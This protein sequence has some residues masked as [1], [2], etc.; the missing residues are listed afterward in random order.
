M[1]RK[2]ERERELIEDIYNLI[3]IAIKLSRIICF[4]QDGNRRPTPS[5]KPPPLDSSF[6]RDKN[7]STTENSQYNLR[8]ESEISQE[9]S[10]IKKDASHQETLIEDNDTKDHTN[11]FGVDKDQLM[12]TNNDSVV[13]NTTK[14][15]ETEEST[16]K[17]HILNH[18]YHTP[19]KE[20]KINGEETLI[21]GVATD[22][23][24]PTTQHPEPS[25]IITSLNNQ[26]KVTKPSKNDEKATSKIEKPIEKTTKTFST[27]TLNIETSSSVQV[28]ESIPT[29]VT[30]RP[31]SDVS[32][33]SHTDIKSSVNLEPSSVSDIEYTEPMSSVST[34][35]DGLPTSYSKSS[36]TMEKSVRPTTSIVTKNTGM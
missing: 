7:L 35:T 29:K 21:L 30:L 8:P 33:E 32:A 11:N 22:Y 34:P 13:Q 18:K 14:K 2:R 36:V 3:F 1:Y 25:K 15:S 28:I 31:T 6:H 23:V 16:K 10:T 19:L 27:S 26:V 24:A 17:H 9:S 5:Y 12:A 4:Y 20:N